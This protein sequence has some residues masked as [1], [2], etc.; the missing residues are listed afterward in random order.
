M[1]NIK[2]RTQKFQSAAEC[3][4]CKATAKEGQ[5][6]CSNS[7]DQQER[8]YE[9]DQSLAQPT[10]FHAK[11]VFRG[12]I[13]KIRESITKSDWLAAQGCTAQAWFALR[14]K[15]TIPNE[16]GLFRMEQGREIG[17]L[18]QE[19]FPG[20]VMVSNLDTKTAAQRTAELLNM[21]ST[22]T[23]FEAA[24]V[25]DKFV[26]RADILNREPGGWHVLEVKSNFSDTS[27]MKELIDDLAYTVFILRR[28]GLV[29]RK[30]SLVLL[31]RGFLYG[32]RPD[33]LFEI[34]DKTIE[35]DLRVADFEGAADAIVGALFAD[36]RP[37]PVLL[38]GCRDCKFFATDCLGVGV[39]HTV[40]EIPGLHHTKLKRLSAA[41]IIDLSDLPDDLNLNDCQQRSRVAAISG[42]N[43]H[44]DR[45]I[46]CPSCDSVALSLPR[47]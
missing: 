39:T 3:G 24:F 15:R 35:V 34:L 30:A 8:D 27:S 12:E 31:S 46:R 45:P 4:D 26:A 20:G 9:V 44:Q 14:A 38:S 41:C 2:H 5:D 32:D 43:I 16:A 6:T 18:A 42:K 29:V 37:S 25:A 23:L 21:P 1:A 28:S 17:A 19:L 40:L 13:P 36:E 11:G 10:R 33:H 47:L 7:S 22:D